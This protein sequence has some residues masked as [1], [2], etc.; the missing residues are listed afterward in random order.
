MKT[1]GRVAVEFAPALLFRLPYFFLLDF[2]LPCVAVNQEYKIGFFQVIGWLVV[3]GSVA[4][5]THCS[6]LVGRRLVPLVKRRPD[7]KSRKSSVMKGLNGRNG[8]VSD[9]RKRTW[10][11][12]NEPMHLIIKTAQKPTL[13]SAVVFH[14]FSCGGYDSHTPLPHRKRW[15]KTQTNAGRDA[16]R[17]DRGTSHQLDKTSEEPERGVVIQGLDTIF[18]MLMLPQFNASSGGRP[19]RFFI[20]FSLLSRFPS[21]FLPAIIYH[22]RTI[23]DRWQAA[24]KK[25]QGRP[26]LGAARKWQAADRNLSHFQ[27]RH[28]SQIKFP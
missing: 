16:N 7:S 15:G 10:R 13:A 12:N 18:K 22:V 3:E 11:N 28:T 23:F 19:L 8:P 14:L 1:C 4:L 2:S 21:S 20:F 24:K 25:N 26:T 17:N 9:D 27:N 6:F 5:V